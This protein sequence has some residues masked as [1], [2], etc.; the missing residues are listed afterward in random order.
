MRQQL[1]SNLLHD[2]HAGTI[3]V[4][5]FPGIYLMHQPGKVSGK[6]LPL[7][8]QISRLEVIGKIHVQLPTRSF[9]IIYHTDLDWPLYIHL[10]ISHCK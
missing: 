3:P 7:L 9:R 8:W 4:T 2:E 6:N 1:L 5:L 10:L